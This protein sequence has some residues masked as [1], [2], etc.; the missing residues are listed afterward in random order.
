LRRLNH[1]AFFARVLNGKRI[2]DFA[3]VMVVVAES[4]KTQSMALAPCMHGVN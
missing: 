1:N 2:N 3:E 4:C